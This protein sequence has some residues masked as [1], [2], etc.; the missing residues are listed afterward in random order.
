MAAV[1]STP[2]PTSLDPLSPNSQSYRP[3]LSRPF[4]G[5]GLHN[6]GSDMDPEEIKKAL[7]ETAYEPSESFW[8]ESQA[9]YKK[10]A[11]DP[12]PEGFPRQTDRWLHNLT[13]EE[14]EDVDQAIKHFI[15]LGLGFS[16]ITQE[17]FPLKVLDK[18]LSKA[19]DEIFNGVGL[20]IIR[21][22][23]VQ[24][25]DRKAQIIAFAGISAYIGEHR[26]RQG[27]SAAAIA[28][29]RDLTALDPGE[30]PPIVVKGQT[31]GNQVFH[32]DAGQVITSLGS[33]RSERPRRALYNT[34]SG[35][36]RDILRTLASKYYSRYD[37]EGSPII[38]YAEDRALPANIPALTK[39][40]HLALDALH[41]TAEA[42]AL[43][44]DLQPGDLEFFNNLSIFHARTASEDSPENTRHLL[45]LWLRNESHQTPRGAAQKRWDGLKA[46]EEKFPEEAWPLEAWDVV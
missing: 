8:G 46:N 21:G 27:P 36:R 16:A 13:A 38:H 14:I 9:T 26:Y 28:H 23:P 37:P 7:F 1:H 41:F 42:A 17:T 15:S 32:T 4:T 34:F 39:E 31:A 3:N 20:R 22:L 33:L 45:R 5:F 30:R 2:L 19:V 24:K 44:I 43:D 35:S 40:Q 25:Y 12:I 6:R 11:E 29:L 10:P 18:A